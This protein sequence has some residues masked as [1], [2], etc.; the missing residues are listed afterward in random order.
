MVYGSDTA[1]ISAI[2]AKNLQDLVS[3]RASISSVCRDLDI[4]RTQFNRYLS[5]ESHPRPEVLAKICDYFDYDARILLTPLAE[6]QR[7]NRTGW[8]Y[9]PYPDP[10]QVH[11]G[12]F[13]HGRLPDGLYQLILPNMVAPGL[14]VVELARFFTTAS[15]MKGLQYGAHKPYLESIGVSTRWCDRKLTAYVQQHIDGV[16][17]LA[18]DPNSRM[19]MLCFFTYGF[20]GNPAIYTGYAALT[21]AKGEMQS[22]VQPFVLRRLPRDCSATLA[23]RR[24]HKEFRFDS[25]PESLQQYFT[26]WRAP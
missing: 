23:E 16:S 6:I 11:R 8:P 12:D 18:T 24:K 26:T 9:A 22:Q 4:N 19:L 3:D 20:R 13:D 17:I 25:L 21:Q 14:M 10:F 15:G 2:F 7:E 5:G 1:A